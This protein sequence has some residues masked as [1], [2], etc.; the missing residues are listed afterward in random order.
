MKIFADN[1]VH[2]AINGLTLCGLTGVESID[3]VSCEECKG[4]LNELKNELK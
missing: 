3:K 4:I 2:L 1:K